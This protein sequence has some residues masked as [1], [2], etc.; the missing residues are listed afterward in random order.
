MRVV[1]GEL[2]GRPLK[3]PRSRD[4]RPTA[5]RLRGALFDILAHA[6]GRPRE[7]ER[8]VDLFA[9]TGALAVEALSRGA[10]E[11]ILVDAGSEAQEL[12]AGNLASLGL[13]GRARLLRRD[14]RRLGPAPEGF[15][16][17]LAFLDPPYGR[18]LASPALRALLEGGW[19]AEDALV[20]IEESARGE[21][22]LPPGLAALETRRY[23][24]ARVLFARRS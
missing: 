18:G 10:G 4:V 21:I 20:V 9:G 3:A 1:G 12:I 5:D 2:R 19:L 16:C 22:V 13:A 23:G 15:S 24:D 11:A 6:Y 7:G 8:V 14:A 17:G